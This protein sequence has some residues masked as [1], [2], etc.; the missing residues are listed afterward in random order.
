MKRAFYQGAVLT[1]DPDDRPGAA[2]TII[3]RV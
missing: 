1:V 2:G 3:S